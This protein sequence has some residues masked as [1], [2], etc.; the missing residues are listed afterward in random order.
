MGLKDGKALAAL[1]P[2]FHFVEEHGLTEGMTQFAPICKVLDKI[3][4]IRN[5]S[6]KI[7]TLKM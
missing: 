6:N 5:I 7:I 1:L 4:L 2:S 3:P